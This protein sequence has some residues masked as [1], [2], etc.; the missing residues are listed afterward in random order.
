M[1]TMEVMEYSGNT[2]AAAVA[3]VV[4]AVATPGLIPMVLVAVAVAPEDVERL[5]LEN[6]EKGREAV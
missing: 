5:V 4:P 1:V 2:A 3:A 6:V